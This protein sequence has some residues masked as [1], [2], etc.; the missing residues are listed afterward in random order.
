MLKTDNEYRT[1]TVYYSMELYLD[2]AIDMLKIYMC[3]NEYNKCQWYLQDV[4]VAINF[5]KYAYLYEIAVNI[6]RVKIDGANQKELLDIIYTIPIEHY[7]QFIIAV[8]Y[9]IKNKIK[10]KN[11]EPILDLFLPIKIS[12]GSIIGTIKTFD[13]MGSLL[14]DTCQ[15]RLLHVNND[16]HDVLE[17]YWRDQNKN[18][19]TFAMLENQYNFPKLDKYKYYIVCRNN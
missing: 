16:D 8:Y 2:N 3:G 11:K 7:Y 4:E 14:A 15:K 17:Y 1:I 9:K 12:T 13:T 6:D 5:N 10:N 18:R 19:L